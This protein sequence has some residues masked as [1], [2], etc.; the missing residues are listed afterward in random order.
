MRGGE[1]DLSGKKGIDSMVRQPRWLM[2]IFIF[3]MVFIVQ[4]VDA[5]EKS[6]FERPLYFSGYMTQGVSV[7]LTGD[8][9]D[10][11]EDVQSALTNVF[12]EAKYL[13][14]SDIQLY[15]SSKLTVDWI[16]QIKESDNSWNDKLF[17]ESEGQLNFDDRWWAW[18]NE[19]HITWSND[20]ALVRVGKQVV[21]WGQTDGF[22]LMDQIN[23]LDQRRGFADVEFEN[24]I[25]PIPLVRA[26]YFTTMGL[27]WM[28]AMGV[29]LV[30]NPNVKYVGNQFLQPGNDKLGVWGLNALGPDFVDI[31]GVGPVPIMFAPPGLPPG[32]PIIGSQMGSFRLDLDEPGSFDRD[33]FEYGI[34][35]D[36]IIF[37][38]LVTL[39]GFYGINDDPVYAAIGP[40][41]PSGMTPDGKILLNFNQKGEYA[42]FKFLG[43]TLTRELPLLKLP[44]GAPAP[45]LRMEAL[46]AFD[47]SLMESNFSFIEDHDEIRAAIGLD[48]KIKI[49]FLNSKNFIYVSP[50]L[51]Y[52]R[53][54]D[55]PSG[56]NLQDVNNPLLDENNYISTLFVDTAYLNSRLKPSFFWM[57]NYNAHGNFYKFNLEY[58]YNEKWNFNIGV[59]MFEGSEENQ[60]F[61]V[62]ENKD[63]VYAKVEYRWN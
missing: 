27:S 16:Y 50:Q 61:E 15:L 23:P 55:Y 53:I 35:I 28:E 44:F 13:A 60:P 54:E 17:D 47:N 10:T 46:Y 20:N 21:S 51:Y 3:V 37:D 4:P 7:G 38:T 18:L 6:L 42:R 22:R 26:E 52:R 25:I 11:E 31:P 30:F 39:N 14:T 5:V 33:G 29:Q 63:Q 48:I 56:Y 41:T 58:L 36:A 24:T 59:L 57:R 8:H 12:A 32:L 1:K 62:M 43:A 34:K 40:P 45:V 49:N 9:Y 2:L 19:I